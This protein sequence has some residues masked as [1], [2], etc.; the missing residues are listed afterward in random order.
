[1]SAWQPIASAPRDGTWFLLSLA[2]EVP[3]RSIV[4][5]RFRV[6]TI[7]GATWDFEDGHSVPLEGAT[8]WMPLPEPPQ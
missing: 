1:M 5:G 8:H 3:H 6:N 7:F 2:P 4:I